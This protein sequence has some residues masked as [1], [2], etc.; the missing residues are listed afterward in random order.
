M[1]NTTE[2]SGGTTRPT[3]RGLRAGS[4]RIWAMSRAELKLLVRNKTAMFTALALPLLF[5]LLVFVTSSE[6]LEDQIEL[7]SFVAV[8]L[9]GFVLL[10]V[11]YYNLVSAYV[12][13]REELVL[14]RLRTSEAMD[15]E[16]LTGT[17]VPS[18]AIAMVQTLIAVV[19]AALLL[20]LGTPVNPVLIVVAVIG[21]ATVFVLLAAASTAFTKNVEMAQISTLPVVIVSMLMSGMMIPLDV[22]PDAL[23]N[24]ARFL[25]LT[26]V[27]QLTQLGLEGSTGTADAVDFAG[28]FS[29]ALVPGLVLVLWIYLGVYATRRWF[30]WEPRT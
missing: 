2:M 10:F 23:A 29:E 28:T 1:T 30:R 13:R 16:I 24:V 21:G 12:A 19:A 25:P 20:G 8:T 17:A 18:L 6:A 7:G 9:L 4:R 26:P 15:G 27:V 3:G 11:V 5:V 22:F 14:K